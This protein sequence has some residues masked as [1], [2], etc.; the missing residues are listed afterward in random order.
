MS[1]IDAEEAIG[2]LLKGIDTVAVVGVSANPGFAS[3]RVTR[4]LIE[5]AG[6]TV[7]PV[8]TGPGSVAGLP[9]LETLEGIPGPV[10]VVYGV[11]LPPAAPDLARQ[12]AAIGA[13]VLWLHEGIVSPE[14]EAIALEAGTD[15][16]VN[17]SMEI[18]HRVE[19]K[20][21]RRVHFI[22]M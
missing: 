19:V 9:L 12:A 11:I 2:D 22:P 7:Y 14:A 5:E 21:E 3:H 16:V 18:E 15:I 1:V 6:Y 10:D 17:R 13:R 4:Y 20:G 8:G